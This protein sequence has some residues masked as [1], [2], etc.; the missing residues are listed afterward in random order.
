MSEN[1]PLR[2][3][4]RGCNNL[5]PIETLHWL[6][7]ANGERL[8]REFRLCPT[9]VTRKTCANCGVI[10]LNTNTVEIE[11][12]SNLEDTIEISLCPTCRIQVRDTHTSCVNC[13]IYIPPSNHVYDDDG[14]MHCTSCHNDY[15]NDDEDDDIIEHIITHN[16]TIRRSA[17]PNS[18]YR[19]ANIQA[20][21]EKS[22]RDKYTSSD[23]IKSKRLFGI[24]FEVIR[25]TRPTADTYS[26]LA[27]YTPSDWGIT[28]D[29]SLPS[30]RYG[31]EINTCPIA[32]KS[33]ND[34]IVAMC[35]DLAKH[36][37]TVNNSCGLH[38]HLD[39]SD[40]LSSYILLKRSILSYVVIDDIL[41]EMLPQ[42]RRANRYCSPLAKNKAIVNRER[43]IEKGFDLTDF[44]KSQSVNDIEHS[45]YKTTDPQRIA[46]LKGYHQAEPRYHGINFHALFSGHGTVEI[47][48]LQ[49]TID[50][51]LILNWVALHQHVI[52]SCSIT[53]E[54]IAE[55]LMGITNLLERFN[56]YAEL[57][58]MPK[59][60]KDFCLEQI[61][62]NNK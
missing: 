4:C 3:R 56:I 36:G 8:G 1:K 10:H 2:S 43:N 33:G 59:Y 52:D 23:I 57:T 38:V 21:K 45:F 49:G 32:G 14:E 15:V 46:S 30:D 40:L 9:C 13:G 27:S 37:W 11:P 19:S 51:D 39:G 34:M 22:N 18:I 41:L 55:K 35:N 16:P 24:E 7:D 31:I 26:D 53:T 61:K 28:S 12:N 44:L 54:T 29:A 6:L 25:E 42:N 50:P 20:G 48:Y 17:N 47:R 5:T 60:I 62:I 58:R